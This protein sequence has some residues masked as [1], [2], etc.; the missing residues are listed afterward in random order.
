MA[1]IIETTLPAAYDPARRNRRLLTESSPPGQLGLVR[2]A[3]PVTSTPAWAPL[4]LGIPGRPGV[5]SVKCARRPS[6][7][8]TGEKHRPSSGSSPRGW[9][10]RG[11]RRE[12]LTPRL[13][14]LDSRLRNSRPHSQKGGPMLRRPIILLAVVAS[15]LL[16]ATSAPALPRT[17]R[18]FHST[19][20]FAPEEACGEAIQLSGTL[21]A[22]FSFTETSSGNVQV[23]FHFNP[24]GITGTGLTTGASYHATGVT[25]GTTTTR[26]TGGI[27]DTFVNSFKIIGQGSAPNFLET[28]VIHVTVNANDE[29][30]ASVDHSSI[31]CACN[32]HLSK[33]R[34]R[35]CSRPPAAS[36][37]RRGLV[38]HSRFGV[39]AARRITRW[40]TSPMK[41]R[42]S[43]CCSRC[44]WSRSRRLPANSCDTA[45][46]GADAARHGERPDPARRVHLP[47]LFVGPH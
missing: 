7:T 27:S 14:S 42:C 25:R 47:R 29:V 40:R 19:S 45:S 5:H 36:G 32:V 10:R 6:V 3:R 44:S 11:N 39:G 38:W 12:T 37:R 13:D 35:V 16:A 2:R 4:R 9:D 41:K 17:P 28:D 30:T 46:A 21:L 23:G 31:R 33:G 1:T 22:V 43:C 26:A 18:R 34:L 15:S 8:R 24:Q 20:F